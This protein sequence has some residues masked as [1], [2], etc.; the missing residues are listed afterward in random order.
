MQVMEAQAEL[1]SLDEVAACPLVQA[2]APKF[3]VF[4][5]AAPNLLRPS[6]SVEQFAVD[7]T[8]LLFPDQ[9]YICAIIASKQMPT[10][11]LHTTAPAV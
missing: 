11:R 7:L 9:A 1:D 4:F 10:S 6:T 8:G 3:A 2:H 5:A